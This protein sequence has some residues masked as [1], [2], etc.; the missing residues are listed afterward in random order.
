MKALKIENNFIAQQLGLKI[1][2]GGQIKTE[3]N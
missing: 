3:N 2:F 1:H